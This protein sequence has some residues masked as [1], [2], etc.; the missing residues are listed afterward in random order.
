MRTSRGDGVKIR[1][2]YIAFRVSGGRIDRERVVDILRSLLQ[3]VSIDAPEAEPK[4]ILYDEASQRG[5]LRCGHRLLAQVKDKIGGV[6]GIDGKSAKFVIL[7]VS[8]TIKAAKRKFLSP[9]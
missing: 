2:R 5:L 4:L 6:E 1:R 9:R 8:G 7:G 3:Q